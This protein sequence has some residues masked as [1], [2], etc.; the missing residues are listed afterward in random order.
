LTVEDLPEDQDWKGTK[1]V[2]WISLDS[3]T[4]NIQLSSQVNVELVEFDHLIVV[5]KVEEDMLLD[6]IVNHNSKFVTQAIAESGVR[7]LNIGDTL[8]FE[9]RG[10][11]IIDDIRKDADTVTYVAIFIPDGK[12]KGLASIP[13]K[14]YIFM[15]IRSTK[16][17]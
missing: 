11:Y 13:T 6:N 7:S 3:P 12:T 5:K 1:K 4:V 14:V 15:H 10:Y 2:N 16:A 8:Q 17:R 9:R